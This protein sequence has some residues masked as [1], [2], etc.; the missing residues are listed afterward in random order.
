MT[1]SDIAL[2][3]HALHVSYGVIPALRGVSIAVA[4]GTVTTVVGPNGAGKTTLLRSI[5]G[6]EPCRS[7]EIRLQG[8][9]VTGQ[10]PW[11][12]A[13]KGIAHVPQGRRCFAGL[14]VDE[15]LRI[16]AYRLS[17]TRAAE[18]SGL[19]YE[20]FPVLRE[21]RDQPAGQ[22]SGGQQQMVAV[23]RA[24]MSAPE[25]LLLDEPALGL[26]PLLVQELAK[27]LAQVAERFRLAIL[28]AEQ[29]TRLALRS[30]SY[31][32]VL[33]SGEIVLEGSSAEVAPQM[34]AAY[35]G[36]QGP[37]QSPARDAAGTDASAAP[38]S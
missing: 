30:A 5:S 15:N 12:L 11:D 32:Y 16:G 14:T 38:R 6:L 10:K 17:P 13:R 25:V 24:L 31:V 37:V 23:G 22:L 7:G 19:V 21:K 18:Q 1:S 9:P 20:A 26:S 2:S 29:N 27:M 28:L 34:Q 36:H 3:V 33:R 35:F 8:E 4:K